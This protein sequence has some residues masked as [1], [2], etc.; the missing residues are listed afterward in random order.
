MAR[1]P[2]ALLLAAAAPAAAGLWEEVGRNTDVTASAAVDSRCLRP[3]RAPD[4]GPV[5]VLGA[6][7]T[8]SVPGSGLNL[9][10]DARAERSLD[11]TPRLDQ[12]AAGIALRRFGDAHLAELGVSFERNLGANPAVPSR[13]FGETTFH[14]Q[15]AWSLGSAD[16]NPLSLTLA[17]SATPR[18]E[19]SVTEAMLS[20]PLAAWDDRA[21]SAF[22]TVG[23]LRATDADGDG[24]GRVEGW[25][26]GGAGVMVD[27]VPVPGT[28]LYMKGDAQAAT[29]APGR[30]DGRI[31]LGWERTF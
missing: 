6:A 21:L 10:L 30:M 18:R 25:S 7:A 28:R 4:L 26:Y 8:L 9:V 1:A 29:E 12:R 5:G 16:E 20:R 3:G 31:S 14:A 11:G 27:W 24:Q 13:S 19:E 15:V 2:L 22:L 17:V 23:T